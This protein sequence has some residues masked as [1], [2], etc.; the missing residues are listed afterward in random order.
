MDRC[1]VKPLGE[2]ELERELVLRVLHDLERTLAEVT[3]RGAV[4]RDAGYG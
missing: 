4:E 1:G 3:A 2:I